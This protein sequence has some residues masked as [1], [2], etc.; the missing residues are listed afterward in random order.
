MMAAAFAFF[1]VIIFALTA[2][3]SEKTSSEL[4]VSKDARFILGS[5]EEFD[6]TILKQVD[7]LQLAEDWLYQRQI[8]W[9]I[10]ADMSAPLSDRPYSFPKWQSWY[11]REDLQRIFH[12]LY[13]KIGKEARQKRRAFTAEEIGLALEWHDK[14]QF[15]EP[16][17]DR[18][19][20]ERWLEKFD[21]ELKQKSIPGMSK[22]LMN[23]TA[24]TYFLTHYQ[25]MHDCAWQKPLPAI[26]KEIS[27]PQYSAFVKTAW[28]RGDDDFAVPSFSS[29]LQELAQH[30]AADSWQQNA[31]WIPQNHQS[32]QIQ[33]QAG[34]TFH[35]TGIH[36]SIKLDPNWFWISLWLGTAANS[37][38]GL[39]KPTELMKQWGYYEI[40]ATLGFDALK[41]EASNEALAPLTT[42][43]QMA[44][45]SSQASWCSNP[46][47]ETGENNHLT[48]C[49]GCHQH[50]G[51]AWTDLEFRNRLKF[52][53]AS[54]TL[55]SQTSSTDF[56]WSIFNGP[57]PLATYIS[58][59]IEYFEVYDQ[60]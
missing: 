51:S 57:D 44:Q 39:D 48:N 52:D 33:T 30:L 60:Y 23:R 2:C 36:T 17:W 6:T 26:C 56:I 53:L 1:I 50:A 34:H 24:L 41:I 25:L 22:V 18:S 55:D 3:S 54:M 16:D 15:L 32:Y 59:E 45:S 58:Q 13:K 49:I 31:S 47:L 28:R 8:A 40:C 37:G 19:R 20:F 27:F 9:K 10:W 46:Y 35:L 5:P 43:A 11:A 4:A 38:F 29:E 42:A 7:S 14:K 21:T 12:Y